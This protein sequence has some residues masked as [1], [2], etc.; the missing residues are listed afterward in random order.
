MF[1]AVKKVKTADNS[2]TAELSTK[3]KH[4]STA[5][6]EDSQSLDALVPGTKFV[7]YVQNV[8]SNGLQVSFNNGNIG[9]VNRVY[10]DKPLDSYKPGQEINGTLMYVMPTVKFA[11]FTLLPSDDETERLSIGETFDNAKVLYTGSGG[12]VLSLKKGIRGL[13][14]YRRTEVAYETIPEIFSPQSTHKCRV[15][16]YDSIER[17]YVCTMERELLKQKHLAKETLVPGQLLDVQIARVHAESGYLMVTSGKTRGWVAPEHVRDVDSPKKSAPK[18][19]DVVKARVLGRDMKQTGTLFTLKKSLID[20]KLPVLSDISEAKPGHKHHGTIVQIN[21]KGILVSF[22]DRVKGLVPASSLDSRTASMRWNFAV[23][24]TVAAKIERVNARENKITLSVFTGKKTEE[25]SFV[26][27]EAVEGSV[28]E[29]SVEGVYVR[30]TKDDSTPRTAFLPA[31]HMAPCREVGSYLS[32]RYAIGD[33]ISALVFSTSPRFVLTRTF[34]PQDKYR[35]FKTLKIGDCLPCSISELGAEASKVLL[36]VKNFDSYGI[37]PASGVDDVDSLHV[38]QLLFAKVTSIDK[39]RKKITLTTALRELWNESSKSDDD[40]V[41]ALDITTLHFN[42]LREL[43][44]HDYYKNKP[45]SRAKI[46]ARVNGVV[47]KVTEHGL[48]LKLE[49]D[50]VGTVRR[51]HYSGDFKPGDSVNGS[52]L[53]INYIHELV[54]VTLLPSL[55]NVISTKQTKLANVTLDTQLRGDI[56]LVTNWFALVVLKGAANGNLAALPT[57]RHVNDLEPDLT[58]YAM[59]KRIRCYVVL[60]GSQSDLVPIC[61]AK[62]AFEVAKSVEL[63]VKSPVKKELKR[64]TENSASNEQPSKKIKKTKEESKKPKVEE[65]TKK[66]K[67]VKKETVKAEAEIETPTTVN[68]EISKRKKPKRKRTEEAEVEEDIAEPEVAIETPVESEEDYSESDEGESKDRVGIP[69]CGF[70]WDNKPDGSVLQPEVESSSDDDDEEADEPASKRKKKKLSAAER[71]EAERQKERE[72]REREEALASNEAPNSV[73]QFDR[74]VLSSPDSSMIWLQYMA[75]HLQAT[76]IEKARAVAKRAIKTINFREEGERL[77]VWQAWLNLESRFG[78]S[79]SLESVFQ[80]AV[81]TNDALKVYLHML[82]VHADAGRQN[83]LDKIVTTIVGKFKQVAQVWVE[84]G[85][86]LLKIGLKDKSRHIMQRALQSLPPQE[87]TYISKK[88]YL[89]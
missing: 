51:D 7:L 8:L 44:E 21:G 28:V 33:S 17:I 73:D 23:G 9:Y 13:V 14:P 36:P 26:I 5:V 19:G 31:G 27:G 25:V 54:E 24:Q 45:I 74:L 46:G 22:F 53:W 48:V 84:C 71:R 10:L 50:L 2:T 75:Y 76:E 67:K 68:D 58:P 52:I 29:S 41:P 38:N 60:N 65:S 72:I 49:N 88:K 64:K 6:T 40:L 3:A 11:Y 35:D 42:K 55:V 77:N 56:V 12:V 81:K 20:S 63:P 59:G 39:K 1:C 66:K 37:L 43:S 16:A 83:E 62:S 61:L 79:E 32:A 89:E 57:R 4:V 34:V 69:A 15:L 87:R 70:Y 47:D 80:E 78:S 86:A 85:C 18:V 82:T 30:L